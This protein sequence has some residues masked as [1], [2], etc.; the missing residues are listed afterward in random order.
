MVRW[1]ESVRSDREQMGPPDHVQVKKYRG[2]S[3]FFFKML[4]ISGQIRDEFIID[5]KTMETWQ[6]YRKED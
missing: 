1:K 4:T 6:I 2:K 3:R 5:G